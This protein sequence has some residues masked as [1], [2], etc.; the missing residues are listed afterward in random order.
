MELS[1]NIPLSL[2]DFFALP[3][4]ASTAAH[5][6]VSIRYDFPHIPFASLISISST[7][8]AFAASSAATIIEATEGF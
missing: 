6:T 7:S 1:K 3:M 2:A 5:P 8:E 4:A